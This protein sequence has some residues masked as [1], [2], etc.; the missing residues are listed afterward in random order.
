MGSGRRAGG[1]WRPLPGPGAL[2]GKGTDA[3]L[4]APPGANGKESRFSPKPSGEAAGRKGWGSG[5][6][7][8]SLLPRAGWEP[9]FGRKHWRGAHERTN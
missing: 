8:C 7:S 4:P 1:A 5:R 2:R 9:E 6:G 3:W